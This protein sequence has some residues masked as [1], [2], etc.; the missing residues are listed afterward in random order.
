MIHAPATTLAQI[1][2]R[3]VSANSAPALGSGR[4]EYRENLV[5]RI[6]DQ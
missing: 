6:I 1:A 2:D 5:N 3:A 4:Q